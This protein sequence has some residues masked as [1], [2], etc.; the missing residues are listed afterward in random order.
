MT[1]IAIASDHTPPKPAIS[2]RQ[3]DGPPL[4]STGRRWSAFFVDLL[5]A[6]LEEAADRAGQPGDHGD[7]VDL[8][9]TSRF[10][11]PTVIL[12]LICEETVSS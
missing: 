2:A 5:A 10:R 8:N 3:F 6:F 7:R 12:F 11:P 1:F 4:G 9:K